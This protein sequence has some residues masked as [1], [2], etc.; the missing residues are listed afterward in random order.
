[1]RLCRLVIRDHWRRRYRERELFVPLEAL[2]DYPAPVQEMCEDSG[3]MEDCLE[4]LSGK[5]RRV[6][7]MYFEQQMSPDEIAEAMGCTA[8]AVRKLYQRA[9]VKLR[10]HFNL[11][12]KRGG[13]L[14]ADRFTIFLRRHG[15]CPIL[16]GVLRT[17]NT[18]GHNIGKGRVH[19]ENH[20]TRNK[21]D[22]TCG[23]KSLREPLSTWCRLAE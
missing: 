14:W 17:S 9:I 6:L 10:K 13:V 11:P 15:K 23:E 8:S 4:L 7:Q 19:D 21:R 20:R 5:Q 12:D 18:E 22:A 3:F 2:S 16:C 1:M